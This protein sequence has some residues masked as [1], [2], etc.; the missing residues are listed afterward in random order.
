MV[1]KINLCYWKNSITFNFGD[2]LSPYIVSK[3]SGRQVRYIKPYINFNGI[4]IT[5]LSSIFNRDFSLLKQIRLPYQKTIV[6][7]GSILSYSGPRSL[8]WGSGFMNESDKFN[9]GKILLVRGVLTREKLLR[10][11]FCCPE[12]YGDPA[13]ILP[14]L[15]NPTVQKK[16][17]IGIIPHWTETSYFRDNYSNKYHVIDLNTDEIE[18]TIDDILSCSCILSSS[19]HGIIVSHAY[20]I[21]ALWIKKGYIHTDGFKFADYFSSVSINMYSGFSNIDEILRSELSVDKLFKEYHSLC[22]PNTDLRSI[23]NNIIETAPFK[24]VYN[25]HEL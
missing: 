11:G 9:G 15:Y 14:L 3:L 16:H 22:L 21:P 24:I 6:G 2:Q 5:I 8:V 4:I 19:L 20:G 18:K 13:L 17:Q 23:Q 10:D 7:I 1:K 25:F 12:K